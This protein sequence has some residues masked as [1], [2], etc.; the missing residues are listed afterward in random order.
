MVL[1]GKIKR[2]SK[3]QVTHHQ[4][5]TEETLPCIETTYVEKIKNPLPSIYEKKIKAGEGGKGGSDY[6]KG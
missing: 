2:G 5:L 4:V 6:D 3:S 1:Q